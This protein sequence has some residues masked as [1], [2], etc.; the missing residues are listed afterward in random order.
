MNK[1]KILRAAPIAVG[2]TIFALGAPVAFAQD[3]IK[4]YDESVTIGLGGIVNQFDTSLRLD[5]QNR[6]GTDINLEN[7][8]LKKNLSSFEAALAWRFFKRHRFDIDYFTVSR[9]GSKSYTGDITIGD[10]DFPVGASVSM[11]N[12]YDLFSLDYRYSLF[13]TPEWETAV[14][15]G[16]YGGKFTF[17]VNAVGNVGSTG[18]QG[19]YNNSV[20][21]TLPLPL[22][23]VTVDWH[24]DSRW[25]IS[26][27][28]YG[29]QA[30]VSDVDGRVY[31]FA[32]GAEYMLMRNFGV[33]ARWT[34]TD[35]NVDVTKSNFN[36][37]LGWRANNASLYGTIVF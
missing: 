4:P 35:I 26:G 33:G 18:T 30:K 28:A 29:M 36:G 20:S 8:G 7:N 1:T 21:T 6:N 23:G 25:K 19:T 2:A 9:S 10:T 32:V 22:L 11:K 24:P 37:S 27:R 16:V 34:Y 5:G 14:G 13:Q 31:N 3:F 15:L 12:K 17:D